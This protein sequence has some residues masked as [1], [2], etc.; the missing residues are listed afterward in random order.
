MPKPINERRASKNKLILENKNK[1]N[2]A[3]IIVWSFART[4]QLTAQDGGLKWSACSTWRS[5]SSNN[6]AR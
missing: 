4:S 3:T 2:D 5:I 1:S 6:T